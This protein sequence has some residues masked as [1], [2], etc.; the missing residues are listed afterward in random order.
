M[1]L[2]KIT[3][4]PGVGKSAIPTN[5]IWG[6]LLLFVLAS[7]AYSTYMVCLGTDGDIPKLMVIPQAAFAVLI[8]LYKFAK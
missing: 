8:A 1:K 2:K 4:N 7:I 6:V 3:S 5:G